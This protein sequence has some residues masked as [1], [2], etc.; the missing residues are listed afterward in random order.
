MVR[1]HLKIS[2]RHNDHGSGSGR[3]R[4]EE[5]AGGGGGPAKQ[6]FH[7]PDPHTR[8]R[9]I[10]PTSQRTKRSDAPGQS[11][12]RTGVPQKPTVLP[13]EV[14]RSLLPCAEHTPPHTMC[15]SPAPHTTRFALTCIALSRVLRSRGGRTYWPEGRALGA[16]ASWHP[17]HVYMHAHV[18]MSPR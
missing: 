1:V 12:T 4:R 10:G 17:L 2:G 7:T 16:L 9:T 3:W 13:H 11:S 5:A 14:G 6:N 18:P 15:S 8:T